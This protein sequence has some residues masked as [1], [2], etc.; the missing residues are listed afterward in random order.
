[1][2]NSSGVALPQAGTTLCM[3]W[4]GGPLCSVCAQG[5]K[6][7]AS[8]ICAPCPSEGASITYFV[9]LGFI[10]IGALLLQVCRSWGEL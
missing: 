4:H 9:L 3:P 5:C 2:T 10:V 1:M 7:D 6:K 8:G